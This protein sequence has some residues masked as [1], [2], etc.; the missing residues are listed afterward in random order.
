V[1]DTIFDVISL[2]VDV[3]R[4]TAGGDANAWGDVAFDALALAIPGLPAVVG[5]IDDVI[6]IADKLN[7]ARKVADKVSDTNKTVKK[8]S[9][10]VENTV[11]CFTGETLI[12]VE[13][14]FIPIKDIKV[15]DLVLTKNEDTNE[16]GYKRVVKTFVRTTKSLVKVYVSTTVI[17]TTE[18]HPFYVV[19]KGWTP[20]Q[21]LKRG[22]KLV[23]DLGH[24]IVIEKV[25][26]TKLLD[27]VNVYNFEVENWHT[28][29]VTVFSILV[30]NTCMQPAP[31]T[32]NRNIMKPDPA[33]KGP[34]TT[35]KRDPQ[36]GK[37]TNY[38]TYR[39]QT[40]PRNPNP[41]ESV[42]RV[43]AKGKSHGGVDTLHV[44]EPDS[45]LPRPADDTEIPKQ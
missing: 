8:V 45:K 44:H 31:S 19:G 32:G 2:V 7:D 5:K 36:T 14:G 4:A 39:P 10:A 34:H 17:N 9:E 15:G 38:E 12:S 40:N 11:K 29:C 25:E 42:K 30:H 33:A 16:V 24:E 23:G 3:G 41:W 20:A 1:W 26:Q 22:D 13:H 27:E 6:K 35:M 43:D 37:V 28:Y 18:K 21:Q